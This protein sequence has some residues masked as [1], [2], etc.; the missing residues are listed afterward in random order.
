MKPDDAVW[1]EADGEWELGPRRGVRRVGQ[2]SW[3]RADSSLA[4]VSSFD[5]DGQL[6]GVAR[7]YHPNGELS[8]LAPYEHGKLHGKQIATR[9]SAGDSPEMRE[10]LEME[11]VFRVETF[12]EAGVTKEGVVTFYGR[13]G[14]EDPIACD[15]EGL[16][17]AP[18]AASLGKL[19]PGTALELVAPF[20]EGMSGRT[21]RSLIVSLAYVC[22]AVV[23]GAAHRVRV[24][25]VFGDDRVDI[26]P[27]GAFERP[28]FALA[29]DRAAAKLT[30]SA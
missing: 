7:R 25:D 21:P 9:P 3:W 24:V 11:G 13:E 2:W 29:V 12:H 26:V 22:P 18:L 4:C 10:L 15:E 30:R 14:L 20:L 17:R 5:D 19:R 16:P 27:L 8:L 23:G 1:N 28:A 6:H